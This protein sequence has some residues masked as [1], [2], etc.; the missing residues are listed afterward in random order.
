MTQAQPKP[1][2]MRNPNRGSCSLVQAKASS[3]LARSV[4]A[5]ARCSACLRL[6]YADGSLVGR[7]GDPSGVSAARDIAGVRLLEPV[8]A[9]GADAVEQPVTHGAAAADVHLDQ[10]AIGEPAQHIDRRRPAAHRCAIS[11][12]STAARGAPPAKQASAHRPRWSSGNSR[13]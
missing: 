10:G 5:T 7:G 13:S 12:N 1:L 2:T 8:Q 3:M 11:T 6:A 9:E 4:R